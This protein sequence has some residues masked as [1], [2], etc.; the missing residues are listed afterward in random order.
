[1]F[2]NRSRKTS[3]PGYRCS[4]WDERYWWSG[5]RVSVMEVVRA[6]SLGFD[7]ELGMEF[8]KRRI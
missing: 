8:D 5:T 6:V 2:K 4:I 7:V 3:L 1:M